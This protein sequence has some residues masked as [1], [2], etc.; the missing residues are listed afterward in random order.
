MFDFQGRAKWDTWKRLGGLA[1]Q[2]DTQVYAKGK[3]VEL[4][5][6]KMN[7]SDD[8]AVQAL[9]TSEEGRS[10]GQEEKSADELL[11]QED[12]DETMYSGMQSGGEPGMVS[13]SKLRSEEDEGAKGESQPKE[14]FARLPFIIL[15]C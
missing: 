12:A 4:A 15:A 5:R 10:R 9:S 3:Y 2:E 6:Q 8:N 13:V 7:F 1:P 11:N 14:R